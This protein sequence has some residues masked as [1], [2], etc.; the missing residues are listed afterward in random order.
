MVGEQARAHGA[1]PDVA[2]QLYTPGLTRNTGNNHET[3]SP[4]ERTPTGDMRH[5]GRRSPDLGRLR[6]DGDLA[7]NPGEELR[8]SLLFQQQEP[9]PPVGGTTTELVPKVR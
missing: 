1:H 8:D 6:F 9:E 2:Q 4:S 7:A 3:I 5:T